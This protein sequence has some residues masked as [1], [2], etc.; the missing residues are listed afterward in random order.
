MVLK[1]III[2]K[3]GRRTFSCIAWVGRRNSPAMAWAATT[4]N[5]LSRPMSLRISKRHR[6][7]SSVPRVQLPQTQKANG[8][9]IYGPYCY[10]IR[11]IMVSSYLMLGLKGR[12]ANVL[13]IIFR[14]RLFSR[15]TSDS[16]EARLAHS[17]FLF[18]KKKRKK[19]TT[20]KKHK[21]RKSQGSPTK[22]SYYELII[23]ASQ[24]WSAIV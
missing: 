11:A 3:K 6:S 5:A 17:I 8:R 4:R 19:Q 16:A 9:G 1:G 20:R 7:L 14:K 13:S 21:I 18:Q 15:L 24:A 22:P 2:I 23:E 10:L 12:P